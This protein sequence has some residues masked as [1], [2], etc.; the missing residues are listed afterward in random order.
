MN[1][2]FADKLTFDCWHALAIDPAHE[3]LVEILNRY[4]AMPGGCS[5]AG[6]QD[7]PVAPGTADDPRPLFGF[8]TGFMSEMELFVRTS[9]AYLAPDE[10]SSWVDYRGNT[11]S[12]VLPGGWR[13]REFRWMVY[14]YPVD[15][16]GRTLDTDREP[17]MSGCFFNHGTDTDPDWYSHT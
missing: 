15:V 1:I 12:L 2:R 17:L 16:Y 9:D 14:Q 13:T 6:I 7:I 5:R 4:L 11:Q 8:T 3:H 10:R